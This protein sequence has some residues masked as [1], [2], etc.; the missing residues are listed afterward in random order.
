MAHT[1][2]VIEFRELFSRST[3][4]SNAISGTTPAPQRTLHRRA[5]GLRQRKGTN[6]GARDRTKA[7]G[8]GTIYKRGK[9]YCGQY[10]VVARDRTKKRRSVYEKTRAEAAEKLTAAIA[11]RDRGLRF[12]AGT[13]TLDGL[14]LSRPLASSR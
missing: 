7:N 11:D 12:D 3:A 9:G 14:G 2:L 1:D 8:E 6:L 13:L 5:E 4:I 10:H